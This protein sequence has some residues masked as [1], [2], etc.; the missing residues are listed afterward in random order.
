[1]SVPSF[2]PSHASHHSQRKEEEEANAV[3]SKSLGGK[4][5]GVE[6]RWRRQT[7]KVRCE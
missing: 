4:G 7:E 2:P 3:P 1:M 6:R 5:Y